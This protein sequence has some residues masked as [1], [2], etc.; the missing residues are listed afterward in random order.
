M[1]EMIDIKK[2]RFCFQKTISCDHSYKWS[3]EMEHL[4]IKIKF[5]HIDDLTDNIYVF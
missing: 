4:S 2:Q 3:P 5:F 1:R